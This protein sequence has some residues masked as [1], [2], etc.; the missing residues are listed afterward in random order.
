MKKI[1]KTIGIVF[2]VFVLVV[3]GYVGYVFATYYRLPD[4]QKVSIRQ[5]ATDEVVD[6]SQNQRIV[7]ANLGFGAYSDDF[8]FFYGWRRSITC[9]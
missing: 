3:V 9:L 5:Y 6:L 7:T 1:I 2:L 4:K 8:S